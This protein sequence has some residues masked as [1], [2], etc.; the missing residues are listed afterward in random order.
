MYRIGVISDTHGKLREEVRTI[1]EGCDVI[2]HCGDIDRQ[3]VLDELKKIAPLY[4][5]RGN[6]DGEWAAALPVTFAVTLRGIRFY[7]VHNK[8]EAEESC[9]QADIVLYGHSHKYAEERKGNQLWLNPGS[10]GARR[11]SL[12]VTMA[13]IEVEEDGNYQVRREDIAAESG[14]S[15]GGNAQDQAKLIRSVTRDMDRGRTVEE[16]AK[17]NGIPAQLAEQICRMYA[18]HPGIDVDG[19]LNRISRQ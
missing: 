5:V 9:A 11:F 7:M 13:V 15:P 19:I 6:A 16:I 4:A 14:S 12:P 18:T 2:L 3:K 8:K 17:K 10:C 1:L